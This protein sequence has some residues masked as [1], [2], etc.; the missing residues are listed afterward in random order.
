MAFPPIEDANNTPSIVDG[1]NRP[2]AANQRS[3]MLKFGNNHASTL[4]GLALAH[5]I[6]TPTWGPTIAPDL[7][8][9]GVQKITAAT[10]GALT[11]NAPVSIT[12]LVEWKLVIHNNSG[13]SMGSVTFDP[14][15]KQS[16][17]VAPPAGKRTSATFYI[18]PGSNPVHYQ[19]GAWSPA[20]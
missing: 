5:N 20:V 10:G 2:I 16:G 11:I 8:K 6:A 13:G 15:I 7:S 17:F 3:W 9:G 18:E 12:P 19:V 4:T 14:S 1:R